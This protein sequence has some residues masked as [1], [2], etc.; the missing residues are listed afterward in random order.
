M[1]EAHV[2][3]HVREGVHAPRGAGVGRGLHEAEEEDGSGDHEPG[4]GVGE[5][6]RDA[7]GEARHGRVPRPRGEDRAQRLEEPEAAEHQRRAVLGGHRRPQGD[8][9]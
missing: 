1:I 9:R 2:L 7:A 8:R 6:V 5:E 4:P 3:D